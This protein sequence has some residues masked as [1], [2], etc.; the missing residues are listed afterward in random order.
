MMLYETFVT[1]HLINYSKVRQITN[2]KKK[3]KIE[4][5]S[6]SLHTPFISIL[7]KL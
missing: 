1:Y 2:N 3:N 4:S 5:G 7:I 6:Q